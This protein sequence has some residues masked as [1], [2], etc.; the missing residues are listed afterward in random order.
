[1]SSLDL[2][3][4]LLKYGDNLLAVDYY[5]SFIAVAHQLALNR[6]QLHQA[7]L[8]E[9]YCHYYLDMTK[10]NADIAMVWLMKVKRLIALKDFNQAN[11]N[12]GHLIKFA[13]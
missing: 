7:A 6:L 10:S 9:D 3:D 12:I 13:A 1:L 11:A 2:I 4:M 8:I 5:F